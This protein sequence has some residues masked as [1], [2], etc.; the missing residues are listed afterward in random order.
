MGGKAT[1]HSRLTGKCKVVGCTTCHESLPLNKSKAK[2]KGRIKRLLSD[3]PSTHLLSDWRVSKMAPPCGGSRKVVRPPCGG[4]RKVIRPC[5]KWD[6]DT[7]WN[8]E[9]SRG[10][11]YGSGGE[12]KEPEGW[13]LSISLLLDT[14][15]EH[16]QESVAAK[17]EKQNAEFTINTHDDAL[18]DENSDDDDENT[19][20]DVDAPVVD[21]ESFRNEFEVFKSEIEAGCNN[22][23]PSVAESA[24]SWSGVELSD[25]EDSCEDAEWEDDDWSIVDAIAV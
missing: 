7:D 13:A 1:N 24:D 15:L 18:G 8:E 25:V 2:G 10:E 21:F 3:I 12:G 23:T 9:D 19:T 6:A 5:L 20:D 22:H 16:I 4:S 14:A 11:G 17:V